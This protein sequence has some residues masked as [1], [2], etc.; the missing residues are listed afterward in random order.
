M[1]TETPPKLLRYSGRMKSEEVEPTMKRI[2]KRSWRRHVTDEIHSYVTLEKNL[3][4]T[5][6]ELEESGKILGVVFPSWSSGG[7]LFGI[8][9]RSKFSDSSSNYSI[10]VPLR[11]SQYSSGASFKYSSISSR[12]LHSVVSNSLKYLRACSNSYRRF[13]FSFPFPRSFS[14]LRWF[15]QVSS[16]FFIISSNSFLPNSTG[17]SWRLSQVLCYPPPPLILFKKNK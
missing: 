1:T 2:W 16:P 15:L 4:I 5:P 9:L 13:F 6:G 12:P 8:F 3:R 14:F 17:G 10:S 7:H 11:S